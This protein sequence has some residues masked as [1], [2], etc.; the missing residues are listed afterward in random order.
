MENLP[1]IF[2][3]SSTLVLDTGNNGKIL[4]ISGEL[5]CIFHGVW[6]TYLRKQI[7]LEDS[8]GLF[9]TFGSDDQTWL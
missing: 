9:K 7:P 5:A 8:Y 4:K 3:A 2:T 6:Y 1:C